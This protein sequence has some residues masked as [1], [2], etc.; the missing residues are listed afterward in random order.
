MAGISPSE[1]LE[2]VAAAELLPLFDLLPDMSFFIKDRQG[3]FVAMNRRGCDYCG[4]KNQREAF[5]KTDHDFFP[6]Q[7]ADEYRKDDESV[8]AS[9]R[10]ILNRMESAP[11]AEGSPRLVLTS[12]LPLRDRQGRIIGVAGFSRQ[13][14]QVRGR[15]TEEAR[16]ARIIEHMHQH[17]HET[18]PSRELA[19]LAGLS[20]SQFDRSFRR[21]FGT[22]A[23]QYLLRVRIEA[24]CRR[25][26][27]TDE[28]VAGLAQEFGFY[29][30]AHFSRCFH[31]LMGM[32]PSEYRQQR[33]PKVSKLR[34]DG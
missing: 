4:V 21:V 23:R 14:E 28:T 12:K 11:E 6:K 10:A 22:S 2:R 16:F 20:Q 18:L 27:E 24:A 19:R 29:D 25:L 9:G 1:L 30:H 34:V 31:Q 26:A 15:S 7:R 33:A 17:P 8:M 13:I 5:G 32:T 3:R